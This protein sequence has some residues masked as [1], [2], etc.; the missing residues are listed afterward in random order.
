MTGLTLRISKRSE[1][2]EK[3]AILGACPGLCRPSAKVLHAS[4]AGCLRQCA[5]SAYNSEMDSS[6]QSRSRSGWWFGGLLLL[7]LFLIGGWGLLKNREQESSVANLAP[8]ASRSSS[9]P[10]ST[11]PTEQ[12]TPNDKPPDVGDSAKK[13]ADYQRGI[14]ESPKPGIPVEGKPGFVFSPYSRGNGKAYVDVSGMPSGAK[15]RCPF[16]GKVFLVP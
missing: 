9:V 15:A 8:A 5:P 4:R 11:S 3:P 7:V 10:P 16:T 1:I 12:R 13:F 14:D 6:G 2:T